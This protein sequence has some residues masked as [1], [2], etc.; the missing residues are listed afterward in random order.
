MSVMELGAL[1]E[2]LG[3]IGVIVTLIY[4]AIQVRQN[5]R[6]MDEAQK[7][8]LADNYVARVNQIEQSSRSLALSD[9]LADIIAKGREQGP[10]SLS[11]EEERRFRAWV[12]AQFHRVDSQWYQLQKGMLDEEGRWMFEWVVNQ[13]A[14]TW[15]ELGL[16]DHARPSFRAE[17]DRICSEAPPVAPSS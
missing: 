8:A 1:G 7:I 11:P 6:S 2:F 16:L 12:L 9:H 10:S 17:I 3:S 15:K 14:E 13:S 5:T 4:L